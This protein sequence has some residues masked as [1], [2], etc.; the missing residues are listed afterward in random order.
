VAGQVAQWSRDEE[1][2]LQHLN[3]SIEQAR[4]ENDIYC[5]I[6][7]L[8]LAAN[9][10]VLGRNHEVALELVT[11]ASKLCRSVNC[12]TTLAYLHFAR[13]RVASLVSHAQAVNEYRIGVDWA[14]MAGNHEGAVR[15]KFFLADSQALSAKPPQAILILV[16]MLTEMPD[17]G[18]AY[19]FYAWSLIRSLIL[20]LARIGSDQCLA[21]LSGALEASPVKIRRSSERTALEAARTRLGPELFDRLK[22]TGAQFDQ[23]EA[24]KYCIDTVA[25]EA[26]QAELNNA[27]FSEVPRL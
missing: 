22:A 4:R 9:A 14:E 26:R 7:S 5:E 18:A 10:N 19:F 3:A 24:R 8:C 2:C 11:L 6:T 17:D 21:V 25:R 15:I 20:P 12:P 1:K 27:E 23:S 16:Q 13:G